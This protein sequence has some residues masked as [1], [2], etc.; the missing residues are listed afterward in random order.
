LDAL[1]E[2]GQLERT[3]AV[4]TSDHGEMLMAGARTTGLRGQSLL[5][6][7]EGNATSRSGF[8]YSEAHCSA[9]RTGS[10]MIR[11]DKWK[12]IYFTA[13]KP[14]LFDMSGLYG[15][16]NN[17]ANKEEFASVFKELHAQLTSPDAIT[18]AALHRPDQVL[19]EHI[20]KKSRAQFFKSTASQF[21]TIQGSLF[22]ERYYG[23]AI[24]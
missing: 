3:I 12:Y 9:N 16:M 7:P 1:Q 17:M 19:H 23:L 15:E 18:F 4:Y 24:M 6:I 13:A 22:T 10:F 21:G 2:N 5:P 11:Q 8:A 14:R 20:Q